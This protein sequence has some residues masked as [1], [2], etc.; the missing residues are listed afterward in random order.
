MRYVHF[1]SPCPPFERHYALR[2]FLQ[3]IDPFPQ[4]L[5][6]PA[7]AIPRCLD[8][9]GLTLK[10]IDVFEIH[11]AFAAQVNTGN[12]DTAP[13]CFILELRLTPFTFHK[14]SAVFI[15]RCCQRSLL[16]NPLSFAATTLVVTKLLA[17]LT[18][19]N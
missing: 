12:I 10:D 16:W 6:A 9:A 5:L 8:K 19:A 4:L 17:L 14:N 15:I 18:G 11:E 2:H 13:S 1:F 3:A 7:I